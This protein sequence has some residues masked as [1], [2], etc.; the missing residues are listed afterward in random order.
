[1]SSS[2]NPSRRQAS[3]FLL[4]ILALLLQ[5]LA[6]SLPVGDAEAWVIN[7]GLRAVS[8]SALSGCLLSFVPYRMIRYKCLAAG[9]FGYSLADMLV[10]LMWYG[11]SV[12][13]YTFATASQL[14]G[15]LVMSGLYWV[16]QEPP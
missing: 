15:F 16:R 1:M 6:A 8:F 10:C 11:F 14:A 5:R 4:A 7:D 13:G 3:L 12:G 9:I 2:E